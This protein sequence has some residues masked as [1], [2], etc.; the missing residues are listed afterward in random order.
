MSSPPKQNCA[1]SSKR[2]NN[3]ATLAAYYQANKE[4]IAAEGKARRAAKKVSGPPCSVEG[5]PT[6]QY[7][8]GMC[9][10]HLE[11]DRY[12]NQ[13]G[14][15]ERKNEWTANKSRTCPEFRRKRRL[16]SQ[17]H[18]L[19]SKY[20]ITPEEKLARLERQGGRCGNPGCRTDKHNGSNWHTD[21][22]HTTNQ[23]RGELCANCNTALGQLHENPQKILGLVEYLKQYEK[24]K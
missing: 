4:K 13:P 10:R 9:Q 12:H 6:P 21:H 23:L 19:R 24:E 5:C 7:G 16:L 11:Y 2:K 20:G 1:T 8:R 14:Y 3:P 15:K 18:K 17:R 22:N